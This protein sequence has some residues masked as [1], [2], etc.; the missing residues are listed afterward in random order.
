M[1]ANN[2]GTSHP[3]GALG[4]IKVLAASWGREVGQLGASKGEL[5]MTANKLFSFFL[6]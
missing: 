4:A 3:S 1:T 2:L 5:K 6:V